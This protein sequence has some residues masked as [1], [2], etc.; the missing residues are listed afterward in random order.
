MWRCNRVS[1]V[2]YAQQRSVSTT[3]NGGRW[4]YAKGRRAPFLVTS[5]HR[6]TAWLVS[7]SSCSE[8]KRWYTIDAR[9][10]LSQ[11]WIPRTRG[12]NAD[13]KQDEAH[14]LL[15]K[16]GFVQQAYSGVF[17][18]LP[19]GLRVQ[20]KIER[21]IDHHMRGLGASKLSLSSLSSEGLWRRSGRL[22]DDTTE[23]LKVR[24]RAKDAFL[25]APTHEEEITKLIADTAFAPSHLPLRL[26]QI[27][28]KYRDE[29][30]PRQGL[31]R[32]REFVMK[33]LYTFDANDQAA[34]ET[35][36]AVKAAYTALF[37]SLRIPF[38]V[39]EADTGSMG[40]ILSHEF[41]LPSPSGEDTVFSCENCDYVANE[42]LVTAHRPP[43]LATARKPLRQWLGV[44]RDGRTLVVV[45]Y[46]ASSYK[47]EQK[48]GISLHVLKRI[49]PDLD[50]SV[51]QPLQ[52]WLQNL[53]SAVEVP[54][55]Q[56]E[57][58]TGS[59]RILP[60]YDA[61]S[62]V[63]LPIK[64][65]E[66][67]FQNEIDRLSKDAETLLGNP[68]FRVEVEDPPLICGTDLLRVF[69]GDHC[70]RCA[71]GSL[72][73][74][75]AI[76]LGHNFHLGSRYSEPFEA[77][78]KTPGSRA[79]LPVVMGCHGIGISRL[80]GAMAA[81]LKDNVGLNW[82][83][84]CAPFE[85]VIV[86]KPNIDQKD[87]IEVYDELGSGGSPLDSAI[88]DRN[89]TLIQ[90]LKDADLIGYPVIVVLGSDWEAH[91]T[92]EVQCRRLGYKMTVKLDELRNTLGGLLDQL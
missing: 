71:T 26:Y 41:H 12:V 84:V 48:D 33:D 65:P 42:E 8:S 52:R 51:D 2:P 6:T 10:R 57:D 28:R 63:E 77:V 56:N 30:R 43:D 19:L 59:F 35:Y 16:A 37:E 25:L 74:T 29:R 69:A 15:T 44:Q 23:L 58:D 85:V 55:N 90:K 3:A 62:L 46:R 7:R 5:R 82:P 67:P 61:Q 21:L 45:Y 13:P 50:T 40:G 60:V 75:Q 88:D 27:T 70:P 39:A 22:T 64:I 9:Q 53:R 79:P 78:I 17:Q 80:I 91:R 4:R 81:I 38:L 89:G 34:A 14:V 20:E 73:S 54:L 24:T 92:C 32:T 72:Q 66:L 86:A 18:L 76:E 49:I 1:N 47:N 68:H 83:R 31:L 11:Y 36:N 87:L